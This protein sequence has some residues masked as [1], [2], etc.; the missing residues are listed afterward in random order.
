M[1]D[2]VWGGDEDL[3]PVMP[4]PLVPSRDDLA[5]YRKA[6]PP[7]L[8]AE[9]AA[10]RIL[11][12]GVTPALVNLPW[13]VRSEVHA[14]DYDEVMISALWHPREGAH[15]HFA[16]WQEMPLPDAYFDVV[17]GDCSFNALPSL[18]EYG[19]V[20][21]QVARV[22]KPG[23]PLLT[24]FFLQSDPP[25]RIDWVAA[26]ATGALAHLRA[27]SKRLLIMLACVEE[28]GSI[29]VPDVQVRVREQ[30]GDFDAYLEAMGGTRADVELSKAVFGFDQR[31]NYPTE[32]DVRQHFE[33]FFS[34]I[35]FQFP[36]SDV[37]RYCPIVRFE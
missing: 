36:D 2:S 18:D 29:H 30:W 9:D 20:L 27:A 22:R 24:R 16:R 35:R 19:D 10:P 23:A 11:V 8:L 12:L 25:P 14:V 21:R 3:W 1:K 6:C 4:E 28:D 13:P 37:G 33:P 32:R 15:C 5:L 17:V 26:E 34:D 7:A 31:L